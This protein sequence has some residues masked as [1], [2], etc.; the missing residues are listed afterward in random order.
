MKHCQPIQACTHL[1]VI[2]SDIL[3]IFI[4]KEGKIILRFTEIT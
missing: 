4:G 3:S 2:L 1:L